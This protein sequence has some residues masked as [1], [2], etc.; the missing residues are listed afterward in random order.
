[1]ALTVTDHEVEPPSDSSWKLVRD[2]QSLKFVQRGRWSWTAVLGLLFLNAFWNGIV[3]VFLGGLL[4]LGPD[5]KIGAGQW[6][7]AFFFLIPFE[8]LGLLW[9]AALVFTVLEPVRRKVWMLEPGLVTYRYT[10][11]GL[12]RHWV[13]SFESL[14]RIELGRRRGVLSKYGVKESAQDARE[15]DA[16]CALTLVMPENIELCTLDALTEGEARWMA[17]VVL[18]EWPE[19]FRN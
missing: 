10:W 17:D 9:L 6:W 19:W 5:M 18:R 14:E 7:P 8:L 1:M 13:Y 2:F 11:L 15:S 3:A 16:P 12:G 4:G